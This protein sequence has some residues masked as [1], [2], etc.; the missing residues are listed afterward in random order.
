VNM[1]HLFKKNTKGAEAA[2][3]DAAAPTAAATGSPRAEQPKAVAG[4]R[5]AKCRMKRK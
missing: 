1:K 5:C 4:G 2:K 3:P